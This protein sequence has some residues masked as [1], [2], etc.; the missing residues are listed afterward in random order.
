MEPSEVQQ[1][2]ERLTYNPISYDSSLLSAEMR[3]IEAT[4]GDEHS[5]IPLPRGPGL[6]RWW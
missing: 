6:S 5:A 3:E 4:I 2:P 1:F